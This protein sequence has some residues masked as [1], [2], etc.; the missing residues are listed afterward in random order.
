MPIPRC[1]SLTAAVALTAVAAHAQHA[2]AGDASR[3]AAAP[4]AIFS[5]IARAD[6]VALRQQLGDDLRWVAGGSGGAVIEKRRLLTL[7]AHP[8]PHLSLS[9]AID[10]VRTWRSGGVATVEYRLTSHRTF[11]EY[12]TVFTSRA[13]DVYAL[14]NGRWEMVR[15]AETWLV[16]PP[17]TITI[18]SVALASFV[19]RYRVGPGY[20]DD[21][22]FLHGYL[23][24]QSTA[25][26]LVG[27]P[28]ARLLPVSRD[29]FSPDGSAPMI[30][31]ERDER[32]RVTGYV[33]QQPDG[34]VL[35]GRRLKTP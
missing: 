29:T 34:T 4:S 10:S 24:A 12:S 28:G 14:R 31:F 18:D 17:A 8:F 30:V 5:A 27:A 13:S 20:V 2:P 25:E 33:Q 9:Y 11:G 7:A 21:V 6:T 35:T 15:H 3:L 26:V 16:H 1:L 23:V 22:H 19:G 32:G